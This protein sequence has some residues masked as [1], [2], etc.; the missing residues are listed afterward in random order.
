[1][2]GQFMLEHTGEIITLGEAYRRNKEEYEDHEA[3]LP[4]VLVFGY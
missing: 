1:M 2:A 3:S 4:P